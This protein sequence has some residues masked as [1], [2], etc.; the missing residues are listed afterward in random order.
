MLQRVFSDEKRFGFNQ[1][2]DLATRNVLH[3]KCASDGRSEHGFVKNSN[4]E[5]IN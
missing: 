3:K 4:F 5:V 1:I 2:A